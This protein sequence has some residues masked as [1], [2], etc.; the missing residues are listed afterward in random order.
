MT[1]DEFQ[2]LGLPEC[3]PKQIVKSS[4]RDKSLLDV[5][6]NELKYISLH[7]PTH[8]D[9]LDNDFVNAPSMHFY[10][11]LGLCQVFLRRVR[12][13]FVV[14]ARGFVPSGMSYEEG[15]YTNFF[16]VM[17]TKEFAIAFSRFKSLCV[18]V[19]DN[20]YRGEEC[21]PF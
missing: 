12:S 19:L 3:A 18:E 5:R 4:L 14:S 2:Y 9:L 10:F 1:D 20:S 16:N 11:C 8:K 21:I 15:A 13:Q 7:Y 6:A 17:S